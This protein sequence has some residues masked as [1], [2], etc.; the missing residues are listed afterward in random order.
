MD[1]L[2]GETLGEQQGFSNFLL[3]VSSD[4]GKLR[5]FG[6]SGSMNQWLEF[7]R[8]DQ[9]SLPIFW[10]IIT[11]QFFDWQIFGYKNQFKNPIGISMMV[12]QREVKIQVAAKRMTGQGLRPGM[13]L[14]PE[15]LSLRSLF[16][17]PSC[18][19]TLEVSTIFFFGWLGLGLQSFHFMTFEWLFGDVTKR[20]D[21]N[22][23][24]ITPG[25]CI[26]FH[27]LLQKKIRWG[28]T[29]E[30]ARDR[31]KSE[32]E[33]AQKVDIKSKGC[34][35]WRIQRRA[36]LTRQHGIPMWP[37][38]MNGWKKQLSLIMKQTAGLPGLFGIL[39]QIL[40][41]FDLRLR[42]L[43]GEGGKS[44]SQAWHLFPCLFDTNLPGQNGSFSMSGRLKIRR[45]H[46]KGWF[47][48]K[49]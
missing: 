2:T 44:K 18:P 40:A 27:L 17:R 23:G 47:S 43:L 31:E 25:M 10:S 41:C 3:V 45:R 21:W 32:A 28:L 36:S 38:W 19:K 48:W 33:K 4:Y 39:C 30:Q 37:M 7:E 34:Y 20:C 42:N 6:I 15:R 11:P 8:Y 24:V 5:V 22:L 35:N 49:P 46:N 9:S 29:R 12:T 14:R 1:R 16:P 26:T 13:D